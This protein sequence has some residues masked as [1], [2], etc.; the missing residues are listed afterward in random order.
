MVTLYCRAMAGKLYIVGLGPGGE[1]HLTPRAK[2]AI[3]KSSK[4]VG[5]TTY[6]D[7]V[8]GLV[9]S[10]EVFSS[11]MG[12]EV[13]RAE[14]AKFL[15][16]NGERVALVSSGDAG[17]YGMASL[18]L[19]LVARE[20]LDIEVEVVPGVTS[21][22]ASS[23]LLGAPLGNDFATI[24]L[25]D[26]LTPWEQIEHRLHAAGRGDFVTVLYNPRSRKRR[27]QIAIAR[28]ILLQYRDAGTPAG[29]VSKAFRE[30]E[31]VEVTTLAGM[32][33]RKIDMLTTVI[34]GN[35]QSFTYGGWIITPRGYRVGEG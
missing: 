20:G 17:V 12:K 1:R 16:S 14:L 30:G 8:Q 9:S 19:E 18:T 34:V 31:K 13:E 5:Y 33:S 7:Q 28:D 15:A 35:S 4:I 2:E 23:A 24:N 22:L 10:K 27:K 32:L 21:A 11:G 6:I 3:E 29:V 26:L 25:S